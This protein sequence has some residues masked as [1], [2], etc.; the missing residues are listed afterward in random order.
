MMSLSSTSQF[1]TARPAVIPLASTN[2]LSQK[3]KGIF[4]PHLF[5]TVMHNFLFQASGRKH[6]VSTPEMIL[7]GMTSKCCTFGNLYYHLESN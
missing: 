7:I 5:R 1:S 6:N 2:L 4:S 3:L